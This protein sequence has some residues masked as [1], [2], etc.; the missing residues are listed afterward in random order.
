MPTV[1]RPNVHGK[2]AYEAGMPTMNDANGN[3]IKPFTPEYYQQEREISDYKNAHP[4]GSQDS[5]HP[6]FLGK[7]GHILAKAGNIAGDVVD[8]A[9]MAA[10]PGTDLY[11]AG[12]RGA[13]MRGW[14]AANEGELKQ[15]QGK[16]AEEMGELVPWTDPATGQQT[17]VT[18]GEWG[19]EQEATTKAGATTGAAQ[20]RADASTGVAET[21]AKT[22]EEIAA[23]KNK[24]ELMKI[25]YG[26]DGKPLP[27][28]QLSSQQRATRDMTVAHTRLQQA[29]A[30]LEAAK[31]DPNSPVYKAAQGAMALRQAEFQ[32]K[33]EEQGL[34][35]PSGQTVSRGNA[36]DAA[37]QL[38]PG[39]EDAVKA[40][41]AQFGPIMG[42]INKGE[43][44][45]GDV[46][47]AVQ[48]LYSQLESFYALQPS[49]H[50]FRNAEFVKDF[51]TF[52]GNLQTN[53]DAVIAGLEGLKPTLEAVK[54]SGLTYQQ[55]IVDK[56][57]GG[58]APPA[59]PAGGTSNGLPPGWK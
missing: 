50:G 26:A 40:N 46:D 49:V 43:I 8:P 23:G 11:K 34:V 7:V 9:A 44:K 2:A 35:K 29:Q 22:E 42:R 5:E 51:D 21:K 48:Q 53:P 30:A 4:W 55:R 39:L 19:K 17:L 36:A 59:P 31:N 10:I 12:Q 45:V 1:A 25:G 58:G 3:P 54:K 20:I 24:T 15:A 16:A 27:D 41:A 52:I 28:D 18:R 14:E 6:G 56:P 37:L 32:N 13:Q 57:G 38:L 33:L 47:P